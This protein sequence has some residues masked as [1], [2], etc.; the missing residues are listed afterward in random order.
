[1]K[2][3]LIKAAGILSWILLCGL[4][5][6][7]L[8]VWI[9]PDKFWF[10]ALFGLFFPYLL[11]F[12]LILLVFWAFY[13][14]KKAILFGIVIIL[15]WGH[16]SNN[17]QLFGRS[18][19]DGSNGNQAGSIHVLTYNIRLFDYYLSDKPEEERTRIIE[20]IR[21]QDNDIVCLQEILTR[22]SPDDSQDHLVK[23][24]SAYQHSY[25]N[26][27][28]SA[29]NSRHFGLGIF[30]K[31]PIINK[32]E[33]SFENTYSQCI[34]VDLKIQSDTV[35]IYNSHL[36]SFQLGS[37]NL[38]VLTEFSNNLEEET[39]DELQ[40]I[41][42]RMKR[43]YIK[44]AGQAKSLSEHISD[45]PYPVV[46]CGDFNDTPVSYTYHRI[47][48]GLKDAFVESGSGLGNTYVQIKPSY[49]IDYILH[50]PS[51]NS[52][53]Y[54]VHDQSNSDHYPISTTLKN[55]LE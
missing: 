35:R 15:G 28:P 47:R 40:D 2:K 30:S 3:L 50:S 20:F 26:L 41:S 18:L 10:P 38:R 31:Y 12:N 53:N 27:R 4:I 13:E 9:H 49:R 52:F 45:S 1:M 54:T 51:F 17:V 22:N 11:F 33:V 7:Y 24:L 19:K 29:R 37:D 34:Y 55:L 36:Q 43:A 6:A 25:L 14:K 32:G 21:S 46:V 23:S 8:S 39:L 16:I 44:R 5:L 42:V 48:K